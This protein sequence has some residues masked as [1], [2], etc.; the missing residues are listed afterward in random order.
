LLTDSLITG[1]LNLANSPVSVH[2]STFALY[3]VRYAL[4]VVTLLIALT[5]L[6]EVTPCNLPFLVILSI[7]G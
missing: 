3:D 5:I 2:D 6:V 1:M 7:Y 4:Y